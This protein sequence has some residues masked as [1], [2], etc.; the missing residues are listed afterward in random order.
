MERSLSPA[1]EHRHH[2]IATQHFE[3]FVC[4]CRIGQFV[5]E[6]SNVLSSSVVSSHQARVPQV[7]LA[8]ASDCG[9]SVLPPLVRLSYCTVLVLHNHVVSQCVHEA[10]ATIIILIH[11]KKRVLFLPFLSLIIFIAPKVGYLG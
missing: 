4:C 6:D 11:K 1:L 7:R 2:G 3:S 10:G 9:S 8:A 5:S